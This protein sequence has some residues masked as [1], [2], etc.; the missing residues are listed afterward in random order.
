MAIDQSLLLKIKNNLRISHSALDDDLGDSIAAC[1]ADLKVCG[2]RTPEP[3]DPQDFDPLI[4]N[5]VKL[6]CR[7]EYT[8]DTSKAAE[9]QKRYD[10]LKSCLMMASEYNGE[11]DANE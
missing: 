2:V 1:L 7:K 11:A 4:L 5:A 3:D 10:A 8:D 9:Y 6:Y